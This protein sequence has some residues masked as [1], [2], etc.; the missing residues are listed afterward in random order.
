MNSNDE[1]PKSDN[2]LPEL[3]ATDI[4]LLVN[5]DVEY[6]DRDENVCKA[7]IMSLKAKLTNISLDLEELTGVN[8]DFTQI[9][10]SINQIC[11]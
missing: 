1:T 9:F 4:C 7:R 5:I 6:P 11:L 8:L 10:H 2:L 3:L